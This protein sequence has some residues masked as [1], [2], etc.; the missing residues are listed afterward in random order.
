MDSTQQILPHNLEI[1]N[2][3]D[4]FLNSRSKSANLKASQD[5][6]LDEDFLSAFIEGSISPREADGI[7]KHLLEC[8]FC[9][10]LTA[11]LIKFDY[12]LAETPERTA[13][14]ETGDP[15]KISEVISG[16][17]SRLFGNGNG[18]VFAHQENDPPDETDETE[19]S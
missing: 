17:L 16:L 11:E 10:N 19:K 3:L 13:A 14:A 8:S 2:I 15:A 7:V 18:A 6:H 12:A 5:L 9:L 4:R 1:Q